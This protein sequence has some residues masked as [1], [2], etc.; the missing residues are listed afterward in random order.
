M[1][2]C[3]ESPRERPSSYLNDNLAVLTNAGACKK[4]RGKDPFRSHHSPFPHVLPPVSGG[5]GCEPRGGPAAE[6][7]G[8]LGWTTWHPTAKGKGRPPSKLI[9]PKQTVI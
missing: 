6:Y 9:N 8:G 7:E 1:F 3:T 2:Y 4:R 5:R